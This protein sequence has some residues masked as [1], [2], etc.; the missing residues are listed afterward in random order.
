[1]RG[2]IKGNPEDYKIVCKAIAYKKSLTDKKFAML[3]GSHMRALFEIPEKLM[4]ALIIG[5]DEEGTIWMRTTEGGRWFA[6]EFREFSI[7]TEV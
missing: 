3:E 5:L 2:Y 4:E 7:A 6:K 1:M